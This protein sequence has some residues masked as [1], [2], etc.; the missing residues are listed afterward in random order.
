MTS[1]FD[2]KSDQQNLDPTNETEDY[3]LMGKH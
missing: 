2:D 1:F 3:R